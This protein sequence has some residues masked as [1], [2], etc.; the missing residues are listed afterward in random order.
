MNSLVELSY[1]DRFTGQIDVHQVGR[2]QEPR[3]PYPWYMDL[4][5]DKNDLPN[6]IVHE[7]I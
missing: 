6:K 4:N 2:T 7:I 1:P 5:E 3:A